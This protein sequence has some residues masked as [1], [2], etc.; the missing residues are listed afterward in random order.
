MSSQNLFSTPF[1]LPLRLRKTMSP[2]IWFCFLM[3]SIP[4][5]YRQIWVSCC[6]VLD[7][8]VVPVTSC[9]FPSFCCLHSAQSWE[10]H[11]KGR[12]SWNSPRLSV[13]ASLF[14]P[15]RT[16]YILP[17][18]SSAYR[19]TR[20]CMCNTNYAHLYLTRCVIMEVIWIYNIPY[21]CS[22]NNF[23]K[24]YVTKCI[25]HVS[26]DILPLKL[27]PKVANIDFLDVWIIK[28][29]TVWMTNH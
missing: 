22:R 1:Q 13:P 7:F 5:E 19:R 16:H 23:S 9:A 29:K 14:C 24:R 6:C 25:F 8:L 20:A 3:L 26:F 2:C 12:T 11:L 28:W 18:H 4:L 21:F 17:G 15:L 10:M 27:C